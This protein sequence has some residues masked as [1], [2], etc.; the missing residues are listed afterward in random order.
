MLASSLVQ[1]DAVCPL[2]LQVDH[3]QSVIN[4]ILSH[5]VQAI[6]SGHSDAA[7]DLVLQLYYR[8]KI[9]SGYSS[10]ARGGVQYQASYMLD[11]VLFA[12]MLRPLSTETDVLR[13]ALQRTVRE[14][15]HDCLLFLEECSTF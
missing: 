12:D 13:D 6:D 4:R 3:D 1:N 14:Q 10:R 15:N 8:L 2:P 11:S 9:I 7:R 5:I